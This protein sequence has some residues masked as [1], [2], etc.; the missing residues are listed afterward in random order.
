MTICPECESLVTEAVAKNHLEI[1]ESP[2]TDFVIKVNYT[3]NYLERYIGNE[4]FEV[5]PNGISRIG[6]AAF[7]GCT[8]LISVILPNSVNEI[9]N[10]AFIDYTSLTTVSI[11]DSVVS[12]RVN[13]FAGT[14]FLESRQD[15]FIILGKSILYTYRGK[16]E[17]IR[18]PDYVTIISDCAF[19]NCNSITSVEIPDSVTTIGKKH[20][21]AVPLLPLLLFQLLLQ[22]FGCQHS[23]AVP[24][25]PLSLFQNL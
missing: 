13:A 6:F 23:K 17:K 20:S 14:P 12:I 10:S 3:G 2:L 22:V 5:I 4:N 21:E 16:S 1:N 19:K 9:G 11:P 7:K 8:S 25:F 15:D 24:L 18:I